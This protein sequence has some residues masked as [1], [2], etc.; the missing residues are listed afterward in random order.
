MDYVRPVRIVSSQCLVHLSE[1]DHLTVHKGSIMA[2]VMGREVAVYS[3]QDAELLAAVMRKL[4][5]EIV[6]AGREGDGA[7]F[8]D[9]LVDEAKRERAAKPAT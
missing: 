6:R 7:A 3:S 5:A 9:A 8:V 4:G 1:T 2:L